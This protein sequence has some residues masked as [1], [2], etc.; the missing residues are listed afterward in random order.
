MLSESKHQSALIKWFR[1]YYPDK[2]IFSIPNGGLR[3]PKEA[4]KLK[5]EGLLKGI[6]D[7]FI[8]HLK[9]F[10]EMKNDNGKVSENQK[11][12]IHQLT[13]MGYQVIVCYSFLEAKNKILEYS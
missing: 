1:I 4:S 3:N 5:L 8:P 13:D 7:L 6:P 10:I 2:L 9:L 12:I 11:E